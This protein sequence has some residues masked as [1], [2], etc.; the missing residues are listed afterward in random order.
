MSSGLVASRAAGALLC[1]V[2]M[3]GRTAPARADSAAGAGSAQP[4]VRRFLDRLDQWARPRCLTPDAGRAMQDL[5]AAGALQPVL[6]TE[7]SLAGGNVGPNQIDLEIEDQSHHAHAI[8]MALPGARGG[9]ADGEGRHF[10]YYLKGRPDAANSRPTTA[11]LA[12]A[13]LFDEAM[14]DSAFGGCSGGSEA[15]GDRRYP[16]AIALASAILELGIVLAAILYG[17]RAIAAPGGFG[18][19]GSAGGSAAGGAGGRPSQYG[20]ESSK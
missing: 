19:D 20:L 11:L 4:A 9:T 15:Q 8:A 17:L 18:T 3:F 12:I 1:C 7:L 2:A 16:R 14:P 10:L 5:V 6:G 13:S